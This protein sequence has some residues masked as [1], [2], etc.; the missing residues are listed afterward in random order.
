MPRFYFVKQFQNP[1]FN[2]LRFL[3]YTSPEFYHFIRRGVFFIIYFAKDDIDKLLRKHFIAGSAYRVC[4]KVM[5]RCGKTSAGTQRWKCMSCKS[6][7]TRKIDNTAKQL[8]IF[9]KWLLSGQRQ[10]D[11]PGRGRTFRRKCSRFWQTWP[12]ADH[13]GEVHRVVFVDGIYLTRNVVILI[14]RTDDYVIGWYMARSENSRA[15][16]ALMGPIAPP[17][18][19]VCDGGNGFEKARKQVWPKTRVQRC[20]FHAFIQVKKQTTTRPNLP[21]GVELYGLAKRLLKVKEVDQAAQWLA[22]YNAWCNRWKE[23][24]GEKTKDLDTGKWQWTHARLVRARNSLNTLVRNNTMFTFLDP[25]LTQDGPLPSTNNKLEGGV[26]TQLRDMLRR[27]RGLSLMRRAKAV[28]WW[29]YKHT[30]NPLGAAETLKTMPTDA[31]IVEL[32]NRVAYEP[33][34]KDGPQQWGDG[35][36]WSELRHTQPWRL[37]WD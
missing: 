5:V 6:T 14:A 23:F 29:C 15:W 37:E 9:L 26:N 17:D 32:Y 11:M 30:E 13:V 18:V 3:I 4:G 27:H 1:F 20:L 24:L 7:A 35:L 21:A 36:V 33:Q 22:S 19:V 2:L 8:T 16:K 12:I 34:Q 25:L 28:Y 31:D 10:A